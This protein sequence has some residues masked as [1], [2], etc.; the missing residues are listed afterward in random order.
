MVQPNFAAQESKI[1]F[2]QIDPQHAGANPGSP[3]RG[4]DSAISGQRFDSYPAVKPASSSERFREELRM[5]ALAVARSSTEKNVQ[6]GILACTL[7]QVFMHFK[8]KGLTYL[9]IKRSVDHGYLNI[10]GTPDCSK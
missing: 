9:E 8:I 6:V 7:R 10:A 4:R 2:P 3:L 5:R 1:N